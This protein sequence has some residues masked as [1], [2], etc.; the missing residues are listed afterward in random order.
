MSDMANRR[1]S[2]R[3]RTLKKGVITFNNHY[4][5]AECVVRNISE[6][7]AKLA[8]TQNHSIPKIFELRIHP[9]ERF[10]PAEVMWRTMDALGVRFMDV[11][12][13][14]VKSS[15]EEEHATPCAVHAEHNAPPMTQANTWDGMEQRSS[16]GGR[17]SGDR[18]E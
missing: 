16:D 2:I 14:D 7:G 3:Y 4:S 15:G 5:T 11:A 13:S 18:R 10:R 8:M 9:D 6:H 12:W 17:R 1:A